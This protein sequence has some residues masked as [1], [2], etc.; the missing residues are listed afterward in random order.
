MLIIQ[1][2]HP[3]VNIHGN[4]QGMSSV[5]QSIKLQNSFYV[6]SKFETTTFLNLMLKNLLSVYNI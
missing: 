4:I 3:A 1:I 5:G 6:K 2:Q